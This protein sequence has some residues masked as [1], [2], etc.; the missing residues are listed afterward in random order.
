VS[1]AKNFEGSEAKVSS[2]L[3]G[4][5]W[6]MGGPGAVQQPQLRESGESGH[7]HPSVLAGEVVGEVYGALQL[8]LDLLPLAGKEVRYEMVSVDGGACNK[9]AIAGVMN[10]ELCCCCCSCHGLV[11]AVYC[12]SGGY[13]GEADCVHLYG[14]DFERVGRSCSGSR[15]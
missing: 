3:G 2:V 12:A 14:K 15:R 4:A 5:G 6:L 1:L 8:V 11:Q 13:W 7:D 10:A 9:Q